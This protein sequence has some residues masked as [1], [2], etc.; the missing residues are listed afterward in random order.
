MDFIFGVEEGWVFDEEIAA[1]EVEE[2][3]WDENK[4]DGEDFPVKIIG[5]EKEANFREGPG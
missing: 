5:E 3:G 2:N 1:S 4:V